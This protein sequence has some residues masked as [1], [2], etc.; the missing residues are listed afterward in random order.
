MKALYFA[1]VRET[2]GLAEEEISPP[3]DVVTV[4][5]LMAWLG[6]RGEGYADAFAEESS[7]RA[8]LDRTHAWPHSAIA[9]TREIAFFPP[10]TGG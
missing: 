4:G 10:M 7:I 2:I 3:P 5:D 8:A 9:G 6:Q 1:G